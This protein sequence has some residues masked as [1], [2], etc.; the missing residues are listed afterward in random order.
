LINGEFVGMK[1]S[2]MDRNMFCE[3]NR[4]SIG[5][6]VEFPLIGGQGWDGDPPQVEEGCDDADVGPI[7]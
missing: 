7:R 1:N 6:S 4:G 2:Y 3:P 5:E